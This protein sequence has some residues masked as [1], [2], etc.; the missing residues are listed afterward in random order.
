M[1]ISVAVSLRFPPAG[2]SAEGK[3]G[4]KTR[5]KSVVDG[6]L[7]HI[8]ALVHESPRGTQRTNPVESYV[9][10]LAHPVGFLERGV[11]TVWCVTSAL[12]VIS[13]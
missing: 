3:A 5:L 6:Q 11:I 8:P 10:P 4:P 7:V 1:R 9:G 13:G 2:T 12:S